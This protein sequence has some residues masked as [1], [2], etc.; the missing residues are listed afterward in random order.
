[1]KGMKIEELA[2]RI[3]GETLNLLEEKYHYRI[4]DEHKKGIQR[5]IRDN[6]MRYISE[7]A[8]STSAGQAKSATSQ[9]SS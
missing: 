8:G 5:E 6:L 1:M 9:T 7:G 2:Y 3:A 4:S